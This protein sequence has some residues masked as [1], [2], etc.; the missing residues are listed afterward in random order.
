[1][2]SFGQCINIRK[3]KEQVAA[4]FSGSEKIG[5]VSTPSIII[6]DQKFEGVGSYEIFKN[7]I[8]SYLKK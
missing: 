3:Y 8:E 6:K 7:K 1:M 4:D 5:I 2:P